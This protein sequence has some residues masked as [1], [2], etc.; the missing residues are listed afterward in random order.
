MCV[1]RQHDSVLAIL[2]QFLVSGGFLTEAQFWEQ[3]EEESLSF[4]S[5]PVADKPEDV[6]LDHPLRGLHGKP[7]D[8]KAVQ[9][10]GK[11]PSGE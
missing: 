1:N 2:K 10:S 4:Q 6:F 8:G 11:A 5:Q 3:H 9:G 7:P